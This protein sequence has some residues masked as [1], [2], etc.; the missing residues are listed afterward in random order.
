LQSLWILGKHFEEK[1]HTYH[2]GIS[3]M[4][5]NFTLGSSAAQDYTGL[6]RTKKGQT[7]RVEGNRC[8][9]DKRVFEWKECT[10]SSAWDIRAVV[11][12]DP[13]GI[14]LPIFK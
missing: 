8:P 1:S 6:A 14:V 4:N 10:V 5:N 7:K 11:S 12:F 9:G 3:F 13:I 2:L